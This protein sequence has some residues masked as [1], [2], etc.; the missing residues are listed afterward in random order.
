MHGFTELSSGFAHNSTSAVRP[1]HEA[2]QATGT[3]SLHVSSP[4]E[5]RLQQDGKRVSIEA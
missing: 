3:S 4:G 5:G 2:G 1:H